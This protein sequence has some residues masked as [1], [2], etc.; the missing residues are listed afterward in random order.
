V[1]EAGPAVHVEPAAPGDCAALARLAAASLATPWSEAA[2]AA[3]LGVPAARLWLVRGADGAPAA[4]LA[5]R[6]VE[7]ELELVSLA[8]AA[9]HRR[10]GLA[11][12]L[13]EHALAAEGGVRS[14]HLE[15]R[16]DD[17]GAQAF[18][19]ALGFAPSGRR[20]AFYPGRVD[21]VTMSWR[22]ARGG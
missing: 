13:V 11:R 9:G 4:F 15:V 1:T 5:A 17:A 18:Y 7:G 6:R 16:S 14:A 12:A 20:T 3:E 21:A 19:A 8:V 22:A 10:Q 2:F